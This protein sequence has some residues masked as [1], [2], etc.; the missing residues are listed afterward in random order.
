MNARPVVC[1]AA[2]LCAAALGAGVVYYCDRVPA[3]S[4]GA[5]LREARRYGDDIGASVERLSD[6]LGRLVTSLDESISEA[7]RIRDIVERLRARDKVYADVAKRLKELAIEVERAS[8][9]AG[10]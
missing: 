10:K 3:G 2:L 5:S 1:A 4:L 6:G 7:N 9:E 8:A